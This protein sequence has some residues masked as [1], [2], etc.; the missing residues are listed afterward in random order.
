MDYMNTKNNITVIGAGNGGQA[1]AAYA[2]MHD[3]PVCLFNR[4][5]EKIDNIVKTRKIT[6]TGKIN[7]TGNIKLI[8]DDIRIAVDF[9][10]I[11][12]IV[13][14]ADAH[15][16]IAAQIAPYVKKNQIIILNPG[17][18]GGLLEFKKVFYDL[19]VS[20]QVFLSE[21]Q[22]LMFACRLT[23]SGIVNILGSKDKVFLASDTTEKTK[24]IIE[25]IKFLFPCFLPAKNLLQTSL[26]NIGAIF[27]PCI[28]VFN[29]AAIERGASF[30]FYRDITTQ[31]VHFIQKTDEER[32]NIGKAFGLDLISAENWIS[33]AYNNIKGNDLLEKLKNN[34]AYYDILAPSSIYSRQLLEDIPTG[35]L[36]MV[37]LGK[38]ANVNVDIMD[39]IITICSS[40][41]EIDFRKSGRTL[42]NLGID[43]LSLPEIIQNYAR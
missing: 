25:N 16:E 2:S 1:I 38:K 5:L 24:Y 4:S 40:L 29:A 17:R 30:Y 19:N 28:S 41:L 8:T 23:D 10:D 31:I 36:P 9:A 32:I 27:H 35:L 20:H 7:G 34:P 15:R 43:Y 11:I 18:T 26:E 13:T 6:L 14:T 22:T 12:M 37:E 33:Y 21:A 3:Y 42:K 39:S